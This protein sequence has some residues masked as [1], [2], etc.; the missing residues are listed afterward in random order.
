MTAA[1]PAEELPEWMKA[2]QAAEELPEW[3][4][5]IQPAE[6]APVA[7]TPA[8]VPAESAPD[9]MTAAPAAEDVP[10]WMKAM[11]PTEAAPVAETPAPIESVPDRIP[12][13]QPAEELLEWMKPA[14]SQGE[15]LPGT[16][17]EAAAP[18]EPEASLPW[19]QSVPAA[20]DVAPVEPTPVRPPVE[21]PD[22]LQL[23]SAEAIERANQPVDFESAEEIP[24]EEAAAAQ[25]ADL[26]DWLKAMA[27]PAPETT[28]PSVPMSEA[29][30]M[31][32]AESLGLPA[33]PQPAEMVEPAPDVA[34]GLSE[35]QAMEPPEW[36]R[37]PATTEAEPAA[38]SAAQPDIST[39][40][41]S[42]EAKPADTV[43]NWL[44]G[45]PVP[46]WLRR[47]GEEVS[48]PPAEWMRSPVEKEEEPAQ[49]REAEAAAP[50]SADFDTMSA[51][52]AMRWLEGLAAQQGARPEELI[53]PAEER[54]TAPPEWLSAQPTVPLTPREPTMAAPVEPLTP[55]AAPP[56]P[57]EPDLS[58]MSADEAM[59]WLEGLAAQQGARPEELITTPEERTATPPGWVTGPAAEP[60][61]EE[62]VA[63]APASFE[64]PPAPE[65]VSPQAIE[66][67]FSA[68]SA[69]EAMRWLESLAA[70]QGAAPEELITAPEERITTPPDWVMAQPVEPVAETPAP[71]LPI[72][73]QERARGPAPVEPGP[74]TPVL[75]EAPPSPEGV[76]PPTAEPDFI[77][78]SPD[79]AL[80]W[81]EG[82][83]ARQGAAPEELVTAP[84]KRTTTPPEWVAAQTP[85]AVE[86]TPAPAE[87][88]APPDVE[89]AAPAQ[90][91]PEVVPGP[92]APPE[93]VQ[94]EPALPPIERPGQTTRLTRLAERLAASR[95]AKESEIEARFAADRA[96][97]AEAR[98][99]V[100]EKMEKR[101]IGTGPLA[102]RPGT[103]S[104]RPSEPA[105]AEAGPPP[106]P[107]PV[108]AEAPRPKL[109]P[110]TRSAS[111][112]RKVRGA[113]SPFAKE[114]PD[115]ILARSQQHMLDG[116]FETAAEGLEYLVAS[117]Q[118]V[119][120]VIERLED[121]APNQPGATSLLRV[122][123]DAY[124]RNNQLQ[125]ALDAYRQA[126]GQ[127]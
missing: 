20:P 89:E 54:T 47:P 95:R 104:L 3:M 24:E 50:V 110:P 16:T 60:L 67:D 40:A 90:A 116:D 59:R 114:I 94:P 76:A 75:H 72:A 78:M 118:M 102:S 53:T 88:F 62:P 45:K 4:K 80:R 101:K 83:A 5:A 33:S 11:Q 112:P 61:A 48:A 107:Q 79:E 97:Q 13:T 63:E 36:L 30:A 27:P 21:L 55:E 7:E 46:E 120:D 111:R 74:E 17:E 122:L 105:P 23:A 9:W 42:V 92:T 29:D 56:A 126:L 35:E 68:M 6:A 93:P 32:W 15:A 109:K 99:S 10:G 14:L 100:Q 77:S 66:P 124:M 115:T 44:A 86:E 87:T 25:P 12:G 119:D 82:L 38:P 34:A 85:A 39:W 96:R 18:T 58:S 106:A 108:Q 1:Q 37:R 49:A 103:G 121:F 117:G 43:T 8:P 113:K 31:Q 81:L 125:K 64:A 52:E 57:T 51:D 70:Q 91:P 41:Q 127:I 69:D 71:A 98:Q 65:V 2:A 123:G 28:A 73:D 26:P 84:D 22:F 19:L